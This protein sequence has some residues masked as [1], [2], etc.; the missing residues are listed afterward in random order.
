MLTT[1]QKKNTKYL[2]TAEKQA[3]KRINRNNENMETKGKK[4][5][6]CGLRGRLFTELSS[7]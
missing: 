4:S 5:E 3:W 6:H 2:E 1:V 7:V